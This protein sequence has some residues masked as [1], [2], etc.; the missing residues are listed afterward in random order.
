M[1]YWADR[2]RVALSQ[3]NARLT[4]LGCTQEQHAFF[5]GPFK[6]SHTIPR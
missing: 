1:E 3:T 6:D 2:G 5:L 4:V